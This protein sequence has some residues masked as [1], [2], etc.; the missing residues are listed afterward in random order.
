MLANLHASPCYWQLSASV[1]IIQSL[2]DLCLGY[3]PSV[4]EEKTRA[5]NLL[6][7]AIKN[8]LCKILFSLQCNVNR[9]A[10]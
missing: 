3:E 2:T 6:A 8:L 4:Q 10:A 9:Q 7:L 1:P 5:I